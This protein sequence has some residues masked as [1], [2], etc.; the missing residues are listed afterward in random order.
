MAEPRKLPA[1]LLTSLTLAAACGEKADPAAEAAAKKKAFEDA[2][3][4]VG[5]AVGKISALAA[6]VPPPPQK[7]PY[8]PK[9]LS[10]ED[11]AAT[12][13]ANEIRHE[14]TA[15]RQALQRLAAPAMAPLETAL[16]GVSAKCA[17]VKEMDKLPACVAAMKALDEALGKIAADASAA[18]ASAKFPRI[19]KEA[20]TK[21]GEAVAKVIAD[22]LGPGPDESAFRAK[23][24]DANA[25]LE[26][27]DAAC[28]KA[29]QEAD[30]VQTAHENADEYLR[31]VAVQRK[32]S[33]SL[34]C[35]R[36]RAAQTARTELETCKKKPKSS[37]CSVACGKV[38][39]VIDEGTPAAIFDTFP[40]ER[41]EACKDVK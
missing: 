20:I 17:D 41:E 32:M 14:A 15:T 7:D 35:K 31:L 8:A 11:R 18:G 33:L 6:Y 12:A 3:A 24:A 22:A 9:L 5:P 13:A 34:Q 30:A 28:V 27:I 21:E 26:E 2:A 39:A 16:D 29:E 19:G 4:I 23:R 36:L 38:Q 25:K 1:L 10:A 40:K 37:E